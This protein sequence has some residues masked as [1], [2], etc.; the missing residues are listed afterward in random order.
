[1][2]TILKGFKSDNVS[3]DRHWIQSEQYE[4]IL[5]GKITNMADIKDASSKLFELLEGAVVSNDIEIKK[6]DRKTSIMKSPDKSIDVLTLRIIETQS[7]KF[8]LSL[9]D[10]GEYLRLSRGNVKSTLD[11]CTCYWNGKAL[12]CLD[13]SVISVF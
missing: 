8:L 13:E 2:K 3:S 11:L 4:S 5:S 10:K 7:G 12:F 6:V 1:M 9:M